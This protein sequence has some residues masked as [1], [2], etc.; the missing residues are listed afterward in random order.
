MKNQKG[1]TLIALV[2][3]IVVLLILAG[4]SIA[5]LTG[6]NG[7][8]T[9]AQQSAA[10]TTEGEV[11]DKVT[12]A[13]NEVS[14]DVKVNSATIAD[15]DPTEK[16]DEFCATIEG[17]L[18]DN[19]GYEVTSDT[20]TDPTAPTITITYTDSTFKDGGKYNAIEYTMTIRTNENRVEL[21]DYRRQ[22]SG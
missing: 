13:Y 21:S 3:T 6:E 1:I 17:V 9:R 22:V 11:I 8:I 2:V 12:M 14:T 10:A 19:D 4:T 16:V 5:M 7:I 15:Y 18:G 20:E